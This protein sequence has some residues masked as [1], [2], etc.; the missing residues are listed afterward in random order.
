M[1]AVVP[2]VSTYWRSASIGRIYV[3]DSSCLSEAPCVSSRVALGRDATVRAGFRRRNFVRARCYSSASWGSAFFAFVCSHNCHHKQV[4]LNGWKLSLRFKRRILKAECRSWKI[5]EKTH[6]HTF[7]VAHTQ[8]LEWNRKC[9]KSTD[10]C[11]IKWKRRKF[12]VGLD[13]LCQI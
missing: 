10:C 1:N 4:S 8:R 12:L 11:S 3:W 6:H 2:S 7:M 13:I 9:S 5:P